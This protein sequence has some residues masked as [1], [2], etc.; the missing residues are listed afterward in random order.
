MEASTVPQ[1]S[2]HAENPVDTGDLE[3][4]LPTLYQQ[5]I[6]KS[7]Y[8]R[9]RD[10]DQRREHWHETVDRY[11]DAQ[12][13]HAAERDVHIP[14]RVISALRYEILTL[15]VMP[16]MR[17]MMTAGPALERDHAAGYNCAYLAINRVEA[18]DEALYIL[19]CGTGVGFSAETHYVEQLPEIPEA[20][21]P[22]DVTIVVEDSKVGW[23]TAFRQLLY[24]LY[25]G[26]VPDFDT[27]LVRPAGAP[28]KTMGGRASGPEPLISLFEYAIKTRER[29]A[30]ASLTLRPTASCARWER[31]LS[32]EAFVALL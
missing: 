2:N 16:S 1:G 5:Q 21:H 14:Q 27:S 13:K 32:S 20:L 9:W 15:G 4:E 3:V 28:L 26:V 23:A 25:D 24:S 31:S 12:V 10:Q 17:A 8:S 11:L 29:S 7:K 6:H 22:S 19:C 18:F 30:V